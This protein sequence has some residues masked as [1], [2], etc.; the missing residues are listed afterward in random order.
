[1]SQQLDRHTLSVVVP[2]YRGAQSLPVV[3]EELSRLRDWFRTPDGH[4]VR[5]EE[6]LLVHDC[7]PDN[8]DECAGPCVLVRA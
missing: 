2:V 1:M 4:E 7:G 6:V 3:V 8:S 5:L